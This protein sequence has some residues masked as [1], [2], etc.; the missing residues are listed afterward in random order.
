M[1]IK[2]E[3]MNYK[4]Y[5]PL[6]FLAILTQGTCTTSI[7]ASIPKY[8][9]W[10]EEWAPI[11][12]ENDSIIKDPKELS[13]YF[14]NI[15]KEH[16]NVGNAIALL[17]LKQ[18]F[19]FGASCS[20]YQVEGGIGDENSWTLFVENQNMTI[21]DNA[22][23]FWNQ[24]K[25]EHPRKTK[26][27]D[28]A[29][30]SWKEY[31]AKVKNKGTTTTDTEWARN[32]WEL[33]Y[34]N[35]NLKTTGLIEKLSNKEIKE[36]IKT[37]TFKKK[38]R[39]LVGRAI[40]FWHKYS[41]DIQMM[42]NEFG[43]NAMRISIEWSRVQPE[44]NVWNTEALAHYKKIVQEMKK[45]GVEPIIVLHHYTIPT[46]FEAIGGFVVHDNIHHFVEFALRIYE[47]LAEDATI[48]STF[49]AVEGY[50]YKGYWTL[51]GAPGNKADMRITQT[52]IAHMLESHVLIYRAFKQAYKEK[53]NTGKSIPE[54]RIGI[55]KNVLP[56]D[57]KWSHPFGFLGS[58][59]GNPAQNDGYYSFFK[60]GQFSVSIPV[61]LGTFNYPE[62]KEHAITDAPYCL[63]WIGI[64]HYSNAYMSGPS[65][66]ETETD[67]DRAT[68]NRNYRFY[69]EGLYRAVEHIYHNLVK[70]VEKTT[71]RTIPIFITENGVAVGDDEA[72]RALFYQRALFTIAQTIQDGYNVIGYTPWAHADNYEWGSPYGKKRYGLLYVDFNNPELPR[73]VKEGARY[74]A[75]FIKDFFRQFTR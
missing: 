49:N 18:P 58:Y 73:R 67:P 17:G 28:N 40:D 13:V 70:D 60:K 7:A 45:H 19:Y 42:K 68:L 3:H 51:D 12:A 62:K 44:Q 32:A 64:N 36:Q 37:A 48:W 26:E 53:N 1:S 46:W 35:P 21:A 61:K 72:K 69:P 41:Q 55:Q 66:R 33:L 11:Y 6:L 50:A 34:G 14:A 24:W 15:V 74:Y 27:S 22:I 38:I 54:P 57:W 25:Q 10:E 65:E 63:D 31:R 59:F 23:I 39:E 29:I 43:I 16:I 56:L 4:K 71:G 5:L 47:E 9:H 52:I 75:N 8:L 2:G 30:N 20:S